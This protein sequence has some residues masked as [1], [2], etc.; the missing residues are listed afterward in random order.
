MDNVDLREYDLYGILGIKSDASIR[1]IKHAYRKKI[2]KIHPDKVGNNSY[3]NSVALLNRIYNILSDSDNRKVYDNHN[4]SFDEL[5][6]NSRNYKQERKQE[7]INESNFNEKFDQNK[8]LDPTDI[9]Y[10][11]YGKDLKPRT[12]STCYI[13][14]KKPKKIIKDFNIDKFNRIFEYYNKNSEEPQ[15]VKESE[16]SLVGVSSIS[17]YNGLMIVG[18][19]QD[20]FSGDFYSDYKTGFKK[21]HKNPKKISNKIDYKTKKEKKL[22]QTDFNNKL[23]KVSNSRIKIEPKQTGEDYDKQK[24]KKEKKEIKKNKKIIQKY[25]QCY[26]QELI[27]QAMNS[28]LETSNARKPSF[29]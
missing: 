25:A 16:T 27:E 21:S 6:N 9:G 11:E 8:T 15:E 4:S 3:N 20:D 18:Y 24:K 1:E 29:L 17:S 26:P 12:S 28:Q 23:I 14:P 7:D 22:T 2:K 13:Q 10:G 19:T 5:K